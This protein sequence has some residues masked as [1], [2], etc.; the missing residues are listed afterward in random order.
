[1][2]KTV[3]KNNET[4]ALSE[5]KSSGRSDQWLAR[6]L[7][8]LI[9]DPAI[10]FVLPDGTS[11]SATEG[12]SKTSIIINDRSALL[13]ML[14]N[15]EYYFGE[16]YTS[17]R[18]D[19]EGNLIELLSEGYRKLYS[20]DR[21]QLLRILY[22]A[23]R[24]I[25][26]LLGL[27]DIRENIYH[28]YDI[29]NSF[30]QLWLDKEMQYTCAYYP[31]QSYTLEDAQLAKMHHICQK[32][33][34][35]PGQT[36]VEAGCGWGGLAR[37]MAR[38]YGVKVRAYNIS[39][40]QVKYANERARQEGLSDQVEYVEDDFRNIRGKYD[41]FVSVGMLEHVG[42]KNFRDLGKVIDSCL[43]ENG[44][45]LIHSIGFNRPRYLNQWIEKRIFPGANPP[46]ISQI[47]NIF[48]PFNFAVL[49]IENLRL[50][51]ARTLE[52][53]L[54]RFDANLDTIRDDF[55]ETF[56]R[57]WRLYLCGSVSAFLNGNMQLFQVV[58]SRMQN[59]SIPWS[60]AYL[61]SETRENE[62]TEL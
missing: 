35:K 27:E 14:L 7:L 19:I 26:V 32:L 51:Y 55:D 53:W 5:T 40:E 22:Y 30:Y 9:G 4:T 59:N 24:K 48:E 16:M 52:H 3:I 33:M 42:I 21:N 46:S 18:I 29:G 57:T 2:S 56:I 39:R 47:M 43:I 54:A 60:R 44:M 10:S 58:F 15:P 11:V 13:Y 61:Y 20:N 31:E 8:K 38:E 1:M 34:L 17:G 12:K 23:I 50:H 41:V 62:P 28:H 37:F 49:D 6:L 36:V 45:G 25:P